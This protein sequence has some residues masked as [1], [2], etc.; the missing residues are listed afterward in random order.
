MHAN[1]GHGRPDDGHAATTS[2]P[3]E[4]LVLAETPE[5][6]TP[7]ESPAPARSNSVADRPE[8][9][10]SQAE[11]E[12][13]QER[14]EDRLNLEMEEL[15]KAKQALTSD[16]AE[17]LALAEAG[18]RK[19][20][21]GLFREERDHVRLLALIALGRLDEARRLAAP[22]LKAHPNSP[23]ARRV[24]NALDDATRSTAK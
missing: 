6:A 24:Q 4:R 13:R 19:F 14:A 11:T 16:P 15:A 3:A 8:D 10:P 5:P 22:Y 7:A 1:S 18:N 2:V 12:A 23:F 20:P 21:G 17:A 9:R